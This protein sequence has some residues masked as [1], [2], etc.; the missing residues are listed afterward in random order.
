MDLEREGAPGVG[1]DRDLRGTPVYSDRIKP[2]VEEVDHGGAAESHG[3]GGHP[4]LQFVVGRGELDRD[5][6]PATEAARRGPIE[7]REIDKE[8][9][10]R[11]GEELRQ[12]PV[13]GER[14]GIAGDRRLVW[15]E[16]RRAQALRR[17]E[18]RSPVPRP[19]GD[20]D[21]QAFGKQEFVELVGD[22]A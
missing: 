16:S 17:K 15:L 1:D 12:Q 7:P 21:P 8:E 3:V 5:L 14:T 11:Q 18:H 6:H 4:F 9:L 13:A 19:I 2:L 22:P 10:P 20:N